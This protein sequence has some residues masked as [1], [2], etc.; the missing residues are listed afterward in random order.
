[1]KHNAESRRQDLLFG[2]LVSTLLICAAAWASGPH[3]LGARGVPALPP[4]EW[5]PITV[6]PQ[7]PVEATDAT[8]PLKRRDDVALPDIEDLPRPA[9][10]N[11]F[12]RPVEPVRPW[13]EDSSRIA[14]PGPG[15]SHQVYTPGSVDQIP[16]P[17][18]QSEPAYPYDLR[19]DRIGGTV[20]VQF[21]VDPSGRVR[22]AVAVSSSNKG[23]EEAAVGA[24]SKWR[25]RPGMK[26]GLP[27]FTRLEVPVEF[28]V[29]AL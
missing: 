9:P 5:P 8:A 7:E 19:R 6:A 10:D 14:V 13:T 21:V 26:A 11:A 24:V 28:K 4:R 22:N 17:T 3:E 12:L 1:M 16:V 20:T 23:F 15:P 29:E 25:F 18:S 2:S 27:V